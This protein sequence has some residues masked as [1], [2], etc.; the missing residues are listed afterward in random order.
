MGKI[1]AESTNC[2]W[3]RALPA[4]GVD[5]NFSDHALWL[6]ITSSQCRVSFSVNFIWLNGDKVK[7]KFLRHIL[8]NCL[9]LRARTQSI[10]KAVVILDSYDFVVCKIITNRQVSAYADLIFLL[11]QQVQDFKELVLGANSKIFLTM[12]WNSSFFIHLLLGS[13]PNLATFSS[14]DNCPEVDEKN[15]SMFCIYHDSKCWTRPSG[16]RSFLRL[17]ELINHRMLLLVRLFL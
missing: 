8:E 15:E 10:D 3:H 5:E 1:S 14:P 17:A 11:L 2:W 13:L 12:N 6:S 9:S 16:E 4:T 7:S